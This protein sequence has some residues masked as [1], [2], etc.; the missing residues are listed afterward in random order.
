M[1]AKKPEKLL[2]GKI[3]FKKEKDLPYL[4]VSS[5][6]TRS[7]KTG[8]WRSA[9]PVLDRQRCIGCML[10]WKFCPEPCIMPA[11]KPRIDLDYCKGCGIC[12][13]VCP[14]KAITMRRERR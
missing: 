2:S 10:C 3:I 8:E 6:D 12:A 13:E 9:R 4:V 1:N 14:V 5:A 7:N 11:D